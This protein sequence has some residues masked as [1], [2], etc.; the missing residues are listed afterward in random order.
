MATTTT[1]VQITLSS[2]SLQIQNRAID[3]PLGLQLF[4]QEVT[5]LEADA[6]LPTIVFVP[7][8]LQ[9]TRSWVLQHALA[10]Q[11]RCRIILWD[12]PLQGRTLPSSTNRPNESLIL[13]PDLYA[14]S[15]HCV[16]DAYGLL[17][18][19]NG[20]AVLA[21]WSYGG[22]V[23][24]HYLAQYGPQGIAGTIFIGSGIWGTDVQENTALQETFRQT[25]QMHTTQGYEQWCALHRFVQHLTALP[26]P[27]EHAEMLL[28][29]SLRSLFQIQTFAAP[30][31]SH[32]QG[33]NVQEETQQ[34]ITHLRQMPTLILQG[35][36]DALVPQELAHKLSQ[37]I[38][39]QMCIHPECGHTP[40]MEAPGWFNHHLMQFLDGLD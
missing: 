10:E 5:P 23:L 31:L 36:S 34:A 7:G 24:R 16:L 11:G 13:S 37:Q 3:G 6:S 33:E 20:P 9:T 18:F 26:L 39:G 25:F 19:T 40:H 28:T 2:S 27:D 15:L 29:Q 38:D 14:Q 8:W 12:L 32:L 30:D 35:A 17:S 21:A 4:T 22:V 1:L